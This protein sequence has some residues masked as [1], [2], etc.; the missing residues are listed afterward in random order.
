MSLLEQENTKKGR[1]DDENNAAEL[2][3]D[4]NGEYKVQ[5]IRHSA[6]Y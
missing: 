2:D 4:N 6:V 1:V 3:V 5:A